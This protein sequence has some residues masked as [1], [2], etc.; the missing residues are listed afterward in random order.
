MQ[1][2]QL[3]YYCMHILMK[4]RTLYEIQ[5]IS[6]HSE[7]TSKLMNT[8]NK[9]ISLS[10]CK[11]SV[12]ATPTFRGSA[13]AEDTVTMAT[14]AAAL[15]K[16]QPILR[17]SQRVIRILGFNPGPFTLDGTNTYLVGTGKDRYLI[18]T[19]EGKSEYASALETYVG[20]ACLAWLF[21]N[22]APFLSSGC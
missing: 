8:D 17:L 14:A 3:Q 19:G 22:S 2:L 4:A 10:R 13:A 21:Y 9:T 18:D 5:V 7:G 11:Y 20:L 15:G 16:Q 1:P 12:I 6:L